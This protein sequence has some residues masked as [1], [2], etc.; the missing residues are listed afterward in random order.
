M[1]LQDTKENDPKN[2]L[3][4]KREKKAIYKRTVTRWFH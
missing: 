2:V 1:K 3:G 4:K